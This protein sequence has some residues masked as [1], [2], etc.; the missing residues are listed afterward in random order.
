MGCICSK[1]ASAKEKVDEYEREKELN[2]SSAQLV[3]TASSKRVGGG[4]DGSLRPR[5]PVSGTTSQASLGSLIASNNEVKKMMV[6]DGPSDGHHQRSATT[7]MG[8]S[9]GN[10]E[11]SR[12]VSM[13]HGVRGEKVTAGWP[14]WL[15][16]VA[17]DAIK[18]LVPRRAESFEKL[19]KIGQG[20]YSSVYKARDLETGKIVALK[21]VRFL[22]MDP[23]SVRFMAREIHIL[24]K[25]DHPNVMKLEGLVTS[26][27][28]SSLYLVFEYMEH[29]LAGL[30][31]THSIK[32][33]APQIKCYIQQLL[34]GLEH[35]HSRGVLHRDIKGSNLL[36]DNNGVLKIGDFGLA[37]FYEPDQ[38]QPL[39]S[40]VVTLWYR[41][42]E[43]LL[44]AT[45]YGAAIDLWSAGC[46]LAELFAGKHIMPG[47]TEVEQVHKIFK[48]CGS[49]SEV[50]WQR[51]RWAHASSFK[52]Q[53]Q[54]KRCVAETFKDLPSSALSLVDKLLSVEPENRGSAAS[55]L[56][57]DFFTTE[58]LPCDPSSLPKYPPSKE[59]D[60]KLRGQEEK[61][62][63]AET[64]KGRGSE[65]V[66]R[67]FG[68]T[69]VVP[70]PEFNAQGQSNSKTS[71]HKYDP[72]EDGGS[73]FRM[74]PPGGASQSGYSHS[75]S[76][77]HP[78]AVGASWNK[79]AAPAR[80]NGDSKMK[81]SHMLQAAP[82]PSNTPLN[83]DERM[84]GKEM[85]YVPKKNRIHYSGLLMP[86]GGN[87]DD[88]LREHERQIQQAV[89]KA[90]LD[91]TKDQ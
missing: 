88:M 53:R 66:R 59:F 12:I 5:P 41:A 57:S 25:L 46:I 27:M 80:N 47:R 6:M 32:F 54:Y 65:Y 36:I 87:I 63:K 79:T 45:E 44:G 56:E 16:S 17:G 48:L 8:S 84:S 90:R 10:P 42:P 3:P 68:D 26:R 51:S 22:N 77:V 14:S 82:V 67:G 1:R 69:K 15:T 40:R 11:M 37:T 49:P 13:S 52:P 33:T 28:S 4:L 81:K 91:K 35:C 75:N 83:K 2:K 58:P 20:T 61:R 31:A 89:R 38:K 24:R 18:G 62:R 29:D 72:L 9:G 43:L 60:A 76:M 71:S 19:D 70:T 21:K 34:C 30:V 85:G 39:T 7:D 74:E 50:Y 78:K 64:V 86:A 73:G 23:E 55:A